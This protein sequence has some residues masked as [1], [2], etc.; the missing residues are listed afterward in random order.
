MS[1]VGT[2][3]QLLH[4]AILS[5]EAEAPSLPGM[6]ESL[7]DRDVSIRVGEVSMV[8]GLPSSG[9][10]MLALSL[11]VR[12]GVDTL[13]VSAD[14]H[15]ATQA[16]RV[17]SLL[18]EQPQ[19]VVEQ[20]IMQ[21]RE[22][23]ASVLRKQSNIRWNFLSSPTT[24]QI[25]DL[26]RAH[27]ELWSYPPSLLVIDNLTDV[28][29]DSQDQWSGQRAFLKDLKFLARDYNLAALVLHHASL[30]TRIDQSTTP[31][32]SAIQGKCAETPAMILS[33]ASD[34]DGYMRACPV[35][36]R[37][38]EMDMSGHKVTWLD[39]DP[40]RCLIRDCEQGAQVA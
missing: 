30:S 20:Q 26:L 15:K 29:V 40:S 4:K 24:E 17:L 1:V 34:G 16:L 35:K 25:D 39:Y 8:F 7:C 33:V 32:M 3:M 36:N 22:W 18:T 10:S 6:F 31:P 37:H 14:S 27:V 13:Y 23:A 21:D 12:S 2:A 28:V 19:K 9:K 38:G 11:A 5:P